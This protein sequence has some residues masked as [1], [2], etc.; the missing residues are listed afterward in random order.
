MVAAAG[1][2]GQLCSVPTSSYSWV[3]GLLGPESLVFKENK[4]RAVIWAV[5]GSNSTRLGG[6]LSSQALVCHWDQ[7]RVGLWKS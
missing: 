6:E 5:T 2:E 3:C 4:T 7:Q 1:S